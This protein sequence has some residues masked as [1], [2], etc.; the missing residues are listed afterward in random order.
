MP[1]PTLRRAVAAGALGAGAVISARA[2]LRPRA[3]G[4]PRMVDWDVVRSTAHNRGGPEA[5]NDR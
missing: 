3:N 1:T 2:L 4:D 5:S